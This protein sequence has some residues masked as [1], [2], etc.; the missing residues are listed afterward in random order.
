[1]VLTNFRDIFSFSIEISTGY[2]VLERSD[3]VQPKPNAM[4]NA[5]YPGVPGFSKL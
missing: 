2:V 5:I 4:K 3:F 1:M